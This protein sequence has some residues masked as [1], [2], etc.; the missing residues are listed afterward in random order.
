MTHTLPIAKKTSNWCNGVADDDVGYLPYE[1]YFDYLDCVKIQGNDASYWI[2][3]RCDPYKETIHMDIYYDP[4]CSQYAG[5]DVNLREVSGIYFQQSV[6]APFYNGT[7]IDCTESSDG[8]YYDANS[9]MCNRVHK[10]SAMCTKQLMYQ[11]DSSYD[12]SSSKATQEC[13]FIESVRLGTYN[14]KG[15]IYVD[16]SLYGENYKMEV[17]PAQQAGL[18][19]SVLVCVLLG[20]YSCYLHHSITNLLIKSLSH[21]HLLPPSRHRSRNRSGRKQDLA[22]TEDDGDWDHSVVKIT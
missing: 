3:P 21:S 1:D 11:F 22:A 6:F 18:A 9:I 4:Y 13:S 20:V 12:T 5:N 17:T 15:E 8:P 16:S 19:V 10:G 7:C 2:R 14:Q